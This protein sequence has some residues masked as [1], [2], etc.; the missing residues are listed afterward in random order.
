[1]CQVSRWCA[2]T[3]PIG[4]RVTTRLH[5]L[6]HR[7]F[8]RP[9]HVRQPA[10][11]AAVRAACAPP[12]PVFGLR[13]F[14][15]HPTL[16]DGMELVRAGVEARTG[17]PFCGTAWEGVLAQRLFVQVLAWSLYAA[18]VREAI[19]RADQQLALDA[20]QAVISELSASVN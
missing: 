10:P 6:K 19:D 3:T 5:R 20:E 13:D 15:K 1:M 2:M 11:I 17:R 12:L 16:G 9:V 8:A 18:E 14:S 7:F 4:K